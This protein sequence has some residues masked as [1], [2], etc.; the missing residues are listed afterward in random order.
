MGGRVYH[1]R[2][3]LDGRTVA[4]DSKGG[5]LRCRHGLSFLGLHDDTAGEAHRHGPRFL[6]R[7]PY[8]HN[9]GQLRM[10][11]HAH[12]DRAIVYERSRTLC[13]FQRFQL[14]DG[15]D[16]TPVL[17]PDAELTPPAQRYNKHVQQLTAFSAWARHLTTAPIFQSLISPP[18]VE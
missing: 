9:T 11:V 6:L 16:L 8:P 2:D 18:A 3:Q 5:F 7:T 15:L 10:L 4:D 1:N 14:R 12:L 13:R 17:Q